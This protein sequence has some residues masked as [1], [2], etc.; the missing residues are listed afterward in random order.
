M[1]VSVLLCNDPLRPARCDPHFAPQADAARRAGAEV[2]L[3][4]HDALLLGRAD[5]AV[6]RVPHGLG[7]VW[8]RGWMIPTDVYAELDAALAGRGAHLLT[9]PPMYRTAHEL[10]GWYATF[11]EVTPASAWIPG[12]PGRPPG[13]PALARAAADLPHGPGIVKDFVK[14]RKHEWDE[15]CYLPDLADTSAVHAVVS[16]FV[17]RQA[18]S[19]AGGVVL[20]A[21]EDFRRDI[22]EA[23]I[24]WLDGEPVLAT[25]HP[26]TPGLRPAPALDPVRPLVRRL[27]CRFVATDLARRS[28]GAWRVVEVGDGQVSDLADGTDPA[29]LLGPLLAIAPA[30]PLNR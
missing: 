19:L 28:D 17:E 10:P 15:A 11:A 23:R 21:F 4:D 5:E 24:W 2:A 3:V 27:G 14:S 13:P 22:G 20:R 18:D 1:T 6:R 7:A 12:E 29:A 9:T 25:G 8:Y 16:R 26:D 30:P